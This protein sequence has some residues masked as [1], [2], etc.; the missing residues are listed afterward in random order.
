MAVV[1]YLHLGSQYGFV[2]SFCET[3]KGGIVFRLVCKFVHLNKFNSYSFIFVLD[4]CRIKINA[5]S[6]FVL[7]IVLHTMLWFLWLHPFMLIVVVT[8]TASHQSTRSAN[9]WGMC[10]HK[11]PPCIVQNLPFNMCL[12]SYIQRWVRGERE[13]KIHAIHSYSLSDSIWNILT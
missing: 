7:L 12:V 11:Y 6:W 9:L 10:S 1:L 8:I 5:K 2:V 3:T 13:R 4:I